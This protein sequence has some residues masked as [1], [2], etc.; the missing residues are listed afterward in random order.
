[1]K[2][3]NRNP[4]HLGT[5][6]IPGCTTDAVGRGL[7]D[8]HWQRAKSTGMLEQ[9]PKFQRSQCEEPGCKDKHYAKGKC[10]K[11]Y[12]RMRKAV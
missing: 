3:A 12:L 7:C 9:F 1:M 6:V 10:H 2:H 11:H 4:R 5:C 8:L